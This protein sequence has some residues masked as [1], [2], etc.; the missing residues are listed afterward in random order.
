VSAVAGLA[1]RSFVLGGL[2]FL[3]RLRVASL[4]PQDSAWISGFMPVADDVDQQQNAMCLIVD[5]YDRR[6][7]GQ[8]DP[9]ED[10]E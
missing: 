10:F 7:S 1:F 8:R 3:P 5:G 6:A 2:R 4:L 9:L